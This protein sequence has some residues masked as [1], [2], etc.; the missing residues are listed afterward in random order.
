MDIFKEIVRYSNKRFSKN[1]PINN[2]GYQVLRVSNDMISNAAGKKYLI[3]PTEIR[4][5]AVKNQLGRT[6]SGVFLYMIYYN[7]LSGKFTTTFIRPNPM[8]EFGTKHFQMRKRNL[9]NDVIVA[10]GEI[11]LGE[12]GH[13]T[14]N[15]LSGTYMQRLMK[16]QGELK[17]P[18]MEKFYKQLIPQVLKKQNP[19]I[20]SANFNATNMVTPL[21]SR[22]RVTLAQLKNAGVQVVQLG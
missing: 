21:M 4:V 17:Y 20:T 18:N 9:E 6:N 12:N 3:D 8:F 2:S 7:T 13:A 5:N 19:F 16:S 14:Y 22:N 15:M 10:A 1:N 11:R